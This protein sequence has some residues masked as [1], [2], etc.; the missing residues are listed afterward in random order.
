[1]DLLD[2]L[3]NRTT[4]HTLLSDLGLLIKK[5]RKQKKLTQQQLAKKTGLS[6][7]TISKIENGY[8]NYTIISLI[9]ILKSLDK[10]SL[11]VNLVNHFNE[12]Q[13]N[14]EIATLLKKG[15]TR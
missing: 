5:E 7:D 6:R 13:T 8:E 10:L 11:L 12:E 2:V 15:N 9:E 4:T 3:K 14:N 1:M